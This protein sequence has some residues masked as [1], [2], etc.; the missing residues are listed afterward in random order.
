MGYE[1]VVYPFSAIVGQEKLKLALILNVVNPR[2]GGALLTGTKGTGKSL[3]VNAL[4]D[5]LPGVEV[6]AGCVFNCSPRDPTNMCDE[7]RG[8][9]E[10]GQNLPIEKRKMKVVHLPIGATEDRVI[11]TVDIEKVFREGV[12]ALQTGLLAEANRN[13][14][15]I[16]QVNLLPDHIVDDILDA[17][18]SGW[19]VIQR[20]EISITHP[21]RFI[22][23]GSM[24]P[25]EGELRPQILDRF[26]LHAKAE[27]LYTR[28]QRIEIARRNLAFEEDPVGFCK[29]YEAEQRDLRQRIVAAREL[30]P[31]VRASEPICEAV[32]KM[33]AELEVDGHR[34]DI[35]AVKAAEALA[36][37]HGR[38]SIQP[39]DIFMASELALSHRTRKSGLEKPA[40]PEEIRKSLER[41]IQSSDILEQLTKMEAGPEISL[42]LPSEVMVPGI[43]LIEIVTPSAEIP[44]L[45]PIKIVH[46]GFPL[47]LAMTLS[48]LLLPFLLFLLTAFT[49][50]LY[51]FPPQLPQGITEEAQIPSLMLGW[52]G[53]YSIAAATTGLIIYMLLLYRARREAP[54]IY[55]APFTPEIKVPRRALSRL[56]APVKGVQGT[57]IYTLVADQGVTLLRAYRAIVGFGQKIVSTI[58]EFLKLVRYRPEFELPLEK[59]ARST[60]RAKTVTTTQRGRY[61]WFKLPEERPWDIAL[62]PTIRAAAPHQSRR[63]PSKLALKIHPQDVR[64]KVREY[65]PPNSTVLLLDMSES[66]TASLVNVR[67]AI[68]SLHQAAYK[69]RDSVGLVVFKGTEAVILQRPTTNLNLVVRKLLEVGASDFTPLAA[70]LLRAREILQFER[71]RNKDVILTLVIISDGIAN[72]PL[73]RPLSPFTRQR[74]SNPSQADAMDVAHQLAKDNIQVIIIN[75]DH[76]PEEMGI[77]RVSTLRWYSPTDFL[78]G[79]ARTTGGHYYGLSLGGG[80]ETFSSL[81]P[82][83]KP[84]VAVGTTPWPIRGV[85]V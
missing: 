54:V 47:I 28:D 37:F 36:A 65:R 26:S 62:G 67:K 72:V 56:Y 57:P 9:L 19:N 12:K 60:K 69:R 79:I 31:K 18:S 5:L 23:V 17:A 39:E 21:S 51:A 46:R 73:E 6:V 53:T 48:Y 44:R 1:R 24:N 52:R 3:V 66:M 49:V 40:A 8:R 76:R 58:Q 77:Q 82:L 43:G 16:D 84:T 15:Y 22:L 41:A 55:Y 75:T 78:M 81:K 2:I 27:T 34:P 35:V 63:R 4:A 85:P 20:E 14:L 68:L 50:L 7:C 59:T 33:C 83:L 61:I 74:F 30:L 80:K 25:E 38:T 11:G 29:R 42:S 70:G 10:R 32:A 45:P 64:I 71:R 13:I